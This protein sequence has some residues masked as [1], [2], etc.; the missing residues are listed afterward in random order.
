MKQLISY[1][2]IILLLGGCGNSQYERNS[3]ILEQETNISKKDIYYIDYYKNTFTFW[4]PPGKNAYTLNFLILKSDLE[5]LYPWND[6]YIYFIKETGDSIF[7]FVF[8]D[9]QYQWGYRY[10]VK[11]S[12]DEYIEGASKI[13][14]E[15]IISK[16][17]YFKPFTLKF[18]TWVDPYSFPNENNITIKLEREYLFQ[19]ISQDT[20]RAYNELEFKVYYQ[21][22]QE[23]LDLK[24]DQNETIT[25]TFNFEENG[26][27][28]LERIGR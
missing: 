21:D 9:F 27:I 24:L 12:V 25:L 18:V 11:G 17:K 2:F 8:V 26:T 1:S 14:V 16:E 7:E 6:Q 4:E 22:L 13:E 19:K 15:D 20:Y 10:K 28:F 23:D 5:Q 3:T